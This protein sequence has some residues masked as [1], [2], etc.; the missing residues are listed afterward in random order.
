[1]KITRFY[2][3]N[4]TLGR[5]D[6]A[7]EEFWTIEK[8]W[9]GNVRF[10]SCIPEGVYQLEPHESQKYGNTYALVNL[11][12]GVTHYEE[13]NSKRYACLFHAA[14]WAKDVE[15]CIGPGMT[16]QLLESNQMVTNS[17]YAMKLVLDLIKDYSISE[18]EIT[19]EEAVNGT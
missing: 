18:C 14:N 11:D 12:L 5:L 17:R 10:K 6:I 1:M 9:L 19:H 4:W 7:D 13:P 16:Q 8:P 15:G 3:P 2:H